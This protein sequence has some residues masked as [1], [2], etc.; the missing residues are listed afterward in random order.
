MK[1]GLKRGVLMISASLMAVTVS[2]SPS[3]EKAK[4][5]DD[6]ALILVPDLDNDKPLDLSDG[7]DKAAR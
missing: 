4:A 3:D 7:K 6:N 1:F 2:A 5:D